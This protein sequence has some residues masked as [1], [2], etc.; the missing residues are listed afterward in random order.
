L[1]SHTNIKLKVLTE[2]ITSL[3]DQIYPKKVYTDMQ[4]IVLLIGENIRF[5]EDHMEL[6]EEK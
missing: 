6:E 4:V 3:L 5:I 1:V 2:D